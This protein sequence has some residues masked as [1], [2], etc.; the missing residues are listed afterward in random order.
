MMHL[1]G[2]VHSGTQKFARP[3]N[4]GSRCHG[5]VFAKLA[6]TIL[7]PV[8]MWCVLNWGW[9]CS[10][11]WSVDPGRHYV[12]PLSSLPLKEPCVLPLLSWNPAQSPCVQEWETPMEHRGVIPAKATLDQP[13]S[14]PPCCWI[15]AHEWAQPTPEEQPSWAQPK[16]WSTTL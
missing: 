16:F 5:R 12:A 13:V 14:G 8:C 9:S 3:F 11:V 10:L 4:T 15:Q 1:S 7:L 2:K 6:M